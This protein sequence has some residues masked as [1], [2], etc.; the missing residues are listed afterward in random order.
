MVTQVY[1]KSAKC[2]G[3]WS[4]V[5]LHIYHLL[6]YDNFVTILILIPFF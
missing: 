1:H 4:G 6:L 2:K 5:G 3:G